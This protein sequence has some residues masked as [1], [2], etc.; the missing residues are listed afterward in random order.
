MKGQRPDYRAY[1]VYE[2]D[3][4]NTKWI[5]IGVAFQN[6]EETITIKLNAL[7]VNGKIILRRPHYEKENGIDTKGN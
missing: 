7:P 6:N 2:A 4:G 3:I 1:T 5:E